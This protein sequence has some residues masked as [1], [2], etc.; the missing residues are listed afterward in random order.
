MRL[1][2]LPR[3]RGPI[4]LYG[5]TGYTGRLTAAELRDAGPTSCSPAATAAS[6]RRWPSELAAASS[7]RPAG[8]DDDAAL[9]SGFDG[10]RR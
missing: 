10:A 8:L 4:A 6:S 2:I 3:Q 1:P 5:A 7:I 9:R